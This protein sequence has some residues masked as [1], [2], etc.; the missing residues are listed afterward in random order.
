MLWAIILCANVCDRLRASP[1]MIFRAEESPYGLAEHSGALSRPHRAL[2]RSATLRGDQR[3]DRER[4]RG[5]HLFCRKI[6]EIHFF[7]RKFYL[8]KAKMVAAERRGAP[9]GSMRSRE[10]ARMLDK[11]VG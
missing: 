10:G 4:I 6:S 1:G 3:R 5:M 7:C 9:Q 8:K 11:A 2:R